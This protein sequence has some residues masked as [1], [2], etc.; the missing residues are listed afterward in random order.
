M[1]RT[2]RFVSV[3]AIVLLAGTVLFVPGASAQSFPAGANFTI[4]SA[5][6]VT[7]D[8]PVPRPT[9]KPCVVTLFNQYEFNNYSPQYF[10]FNPPAGC[11]GPW[12]KVVLEGNFIVTAGVQYDRT[13]NIWIGATNVW[14]GTTPEPLSNGNIHWQVQRDVTEYSALYGAPQAGEV[15]IFNIVNT[16]YTGIIYGT[17]RLQFYPANSQNP[18]PTVPDVVLP[19][20]AGPTGETVALDSP[21]SQLTGTFSF[22]TNTESVSMEVFAQG[23]NDDEFWYTCVP[24]DVATE[25]Q[26]CT[27][28]GFRE[29]E[30]TIDGQPAGVAPIYPWIFTG[31]IDPFLWTPIPGVQTLNFPPYIVDLTPFAG[32]LSN[33]Q[34]HTVALSVFNAD[35]W[36][37]ATATVLVYEDHGSTT[38]TGAVT[39][40]TLPAEP[41]PNVVEN[42]QMENGYPNGTVSVTSTRNYAITGYVNTSQGTVATT[43][44][45]IINFSNFQTFTINASEYDQDIVQGAKIQSYIKT[46]NGSTTTVAQS[47]FNYPLTVNYD[48]QIASDGSANVTTNITQQLQNQVSDT[49]NGKVTYT[50]ATTNLVQ[51]ADTLM[52]NSSG[53]FIGNSDQS[54][55]QAYFTKD[56]TGYCYSLI[57]DA[58][59]GVLTAGYVGR[60][61]STNVR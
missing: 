18:A 15:D 56:S 6:T 32:L 54:N 31:G 60:G 45:Q 1:T 33:G 57:L 21:T 8:P 34:Q 30:I 27:G 37:S 51:P 28:T 2:F 49:Q 17:A 25:L 55:T 23:Q 12:A 4:G 11:P 44:A 61:C 24:D 43:V 16:T 19:M 10:T 38:V 13:G 7:A 26:S 5:N 48:E 39:S 14:F 50:S 47:T 58:A 46:V 42:I 52:Y 41:T 59:A 9:T 3:A 22:P 53:I 20:S 35:N 29:G 36:F 40:N